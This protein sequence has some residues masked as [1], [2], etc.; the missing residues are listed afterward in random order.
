MTFCYEYE[1]PS[2]TV[3]IIV[4][5]LINNFLNVLLIQRKNEPY[6]NKWALPG[7]FVNS[8]E[9][10]RHAAIRELKEETN[11]NVDINNLYEFKVFGDYGRDPRGWT[12]TISYICF[13]KN[14]INFKAKSDAKNISFFDVKNLPELAFDHNKIIDE[15]IYNLEKILFTSN[16]LENVL[17]IND[18]N[19]LKKVYEIILSKKYELSDFVTLKSFLTK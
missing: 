6:K 19:E 18:L 1:R 14:N 3:D 9:N 7:G 4:L 11:I 12:V 8:K 2:L 15:A 13:V 5:S 10:I 16:I 17:N